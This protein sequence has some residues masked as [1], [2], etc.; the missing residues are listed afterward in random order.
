MF[1]AIFQ[2]INLLPLVWSNCSNLFQ[3]F[4]IGFQQL[5]NIF[6][7]VLFISFQICFIVVAIDFRLLLL[8][9]F[10]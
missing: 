10:D 2:A 9:F 1:K 5:F 8:S 6:Q 4:A 3:H 7:H